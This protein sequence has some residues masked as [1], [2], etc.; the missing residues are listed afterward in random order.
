MLGIKTKINSMRTL[1]EAPPAVRPQ[2]PPLSGKSQSTC[3]ELPGDWDQDE[4]NI[5]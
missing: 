1:Q 3:K 2:S 4:T 5:I